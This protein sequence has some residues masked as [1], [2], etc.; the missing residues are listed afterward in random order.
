M[1]VADKGAHQARLADPGGKGETKGRKLALKVGN[2]RKLAADQFQ[3][4]GSICILARWRNL[5]DAMQDF[6]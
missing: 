5:G 2:R 3:D 6:E 1:K 4:S